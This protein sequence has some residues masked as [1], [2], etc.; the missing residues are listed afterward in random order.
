MIKLNYVNCLRDLGGLDRYFYREFFKEGDM[1]LLSQQCDLLLEI[2]EHERKINAL[3]L[4]KRV[5]ARL[6]EVF[7]PY[8][9]KVK[10]YLEDKQQYEVELKRLVFDSVCSYLDEY[11]DSFIPMS[12]DDLEK[13]DYKSS[14]V[15]CLIEENL[16]NCTLV[17]PLVQVDKSNKYFLPLIVF[18]RETLLFE[19]KDNNTVG[20]IEEMLRDHTIPFIT[21]KL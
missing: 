2:L 18:N 3:P 4:F 20:R 6:K 12:K 17:N 5:K 14:S 9:P 21:V 8:K 13:I 15:S 7:V 1:T 11:C 19:L 16:S 10:D